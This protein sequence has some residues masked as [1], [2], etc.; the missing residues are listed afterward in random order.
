MLKAHL[1]AG[2]LVLVAANV[3]GAVFFA[4]A[5]PGETGGRAIACTALVLVHATLAF[6]LY[7]TYNWA[8][9]IMLIYALFQI[10][11]LATAAVVA[12]LMLQAKPF[13]AWTGVMFGLALVLIPFLSWACTYL[14]RESTRD[15]FT[16]ST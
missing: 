14:M 8:R 4:I 9:V 15:R 11:G 3:A 2:V 16:S 12:L 6:G 13:T 10:A 7:H 1:P 5:C